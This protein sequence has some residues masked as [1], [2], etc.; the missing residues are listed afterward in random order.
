MPSF[1]LKSLLK[2]ERLE[3]GLTTLVVL[4]AFV[5]GA[6]S[7]TRGVWLDEFFTLMATGPE[8]SF[9]EFMTFVFGEP[10]PILHYALVFLAQKLGLTDVIALRGLNLLGALGAAAA[11]YAALRRKTITTSTA[12]VI[13]TLYASSSIFSTYLAE[14]RA[15]FLLFS[16]S[17][18]ATL[19]WKIIFDGAAATSRRDWILYFVSLAALAN[20]H[21]F[22]TLYGGFLA[23]SLISNAA[24]QRDW[25][26]A[27]IVALVSA[28]AAAPAVLT[29]YIQSQ[30]VLQPT[31]NSWIYTSFKQGIR[32]VLD[33][34]GMAI[35]MNYVVI[36]AAMVSALFLVESRERLAAARWVFWLT[37]TFVVFVAFIS[38]ANLF[39]S[40]IWFRY[41]FA[42]AGSVVVLA[43]ALATQPFLPRL[44]V[45]AICAAAIALQCYG[46]YRP[47]NT[48]DG[49]RTTARHVAS[50][51][52][53]CPTTK[54]YAQ[55]W[56]TDPLYAEV[57]TRW[58]LFGY[59]YYAEKY[60][61]VTQTLRVGDT[62]PSSDGACPSIIWIEHYYYHFYKT[63]RPPN[64]TADDVLRELQ[65]T[66]QGEP[67]LQWLGS[68]A[69]ITVR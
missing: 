27:A 57:V 28:A 47:A 48:D 18:A 35:H 32:F 7:F 25:R 23:L 33:V 36:A 50:Q 17:L 19:A 65:V 6:I 39:R 51:V 16:A 41:L 24:L 20:L 13:I 34:M 14:V 45:S 11:L 22:G 52:A 64:V 66:V 37:A 8:T 1:D 38:V 9:S 10:H 2:I 21:Y 40:I 42:A 5:L 68:G 62:V 44:T 54:V 59:N 49:W 46:I 55:L 12:C 30:A 63:P 67:A 15:Y 60:D 3:I 4:I 61:F 26:R 58:M 29:F 53:Q 69:I 43:A 56:G 31:F